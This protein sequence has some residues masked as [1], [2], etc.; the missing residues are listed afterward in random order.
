ME[1]ASSPEGRRLP[2]Q[3]TLADDQNTERALK[4]HDTIPSHSLN[5]WKEANVITV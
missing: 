4:C 2:L 1:G 3:Y 5:T